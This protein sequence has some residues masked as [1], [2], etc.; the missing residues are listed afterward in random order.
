MGIGMCWTLFGRG[1]RFRQINKQLK[2]SRKAISILAILC[3]S[4][5]SIAQQQTDPA[6]YLNN[7][8]EIL[9][10]NRAADFGRLWVQDLDGRI[11]PV[12]TLASE[13]IRKLTRKPYYQLGSIRLT[14][15]QAFLS[16]SMDPDSWRFLPVIKVDLKKG[17][18]LFE[19]MNPTPEG[20]VSLESMFSSRGDYLLGRAVEAANLKK[21][22]ERD[23]FD[24]EVLKVDER[25][26]ILY[27]MLSGQYLRIFPNKLDKNNTW[28]APTHDFADFPMEDGQFAR[29][30]LGVYY[31]Q[32]R[33]GD[34][35]GA[36]ESLG[37]VKTYQEVLGSDIIPSNTKMEA[38]LIYNRLNLNFWLFQILFTIG[39]IMLLLAILRIFKS[40]T[41]LNRLYQL[42]VLLSFLAFLIFAGNIVLRWYIGGH[43]PWS[44][45]YEMLVFV[46]WVL[47]LC[48]F[49]S[50]RQSDFTLPLSTLFSGALLFVSYLDWINPEITNL[51]PVLRS[52]WLKVHV[53][54]I[55]SSYAPLALSAVLGTM[56]LI[57]LLVRNQ[58]NSA[59]IDP[60]VKE[61]TLINEISMTIGLFVL[62]IGTFLGGVWANES[63]GRYWA[64]DP[65]ETWALISIIVYAIILHLRLIPGLRRPL[66]FNAASMFGF[67]AIIMTSFGVNYYLSGLHSYASGDPL[68]IPD[69][70]YILAIVQIVIW[71]LAYW[72][73]G[74]VGRSGMDSKDDTDLQ[75]AQS[76]G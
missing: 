17:G 29:N 50:Y 16:M 10:E 19:A 25:F 56:A 53:A 67:W 75:T 70:V 1:T 46:A 28:F 58:R 23:E 32:L 22:S 27:N 6:S 38:E 73:E 35:S 57:L 26:N 66:I 37:Y 34:R 62:A 13:L 49:L 64:W 7:Q 21:P 42:T 18:S 52:Y 69:F 65:K 47:F 55:V 60:K 76:A 61:L 59:R 68:P 15:D 24:Q 30:I 44:N 3:M 54:T 33:S 71:S 20:F 43:A 31:D 74:R 45:G 2:R 9:R 72:K 14:T 63:W 36:D 41:W 11:K 39:A 5:V 40:N 12:N 48:G 4:G 51:M 8:L